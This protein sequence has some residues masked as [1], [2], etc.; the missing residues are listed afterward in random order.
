[1]V[2]KQDNTQK[3]KQMKLQLKVRFVFVRLVKEWKRFLR[4]VDFLCF[5]TE[6]DRALKICSTYFCSDQRDLDQTV[7]RG[8]LTSQ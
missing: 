3:L 6:L 1:M 4:V 2:K 5:E 7:S 8:C